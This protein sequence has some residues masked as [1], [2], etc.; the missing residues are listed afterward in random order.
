MNNWCR[1]EAAVIYQIDYLRISFCHIMCSNGSFEDI[2]ILRTKASEL[3]ASD[4][5]CF[6]RR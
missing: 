2:T 5:Y 6:H 4:N 1:Y 3:A